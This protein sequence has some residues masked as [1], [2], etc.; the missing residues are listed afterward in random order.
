VIPTIESGD[1]A[2]SR[3]I[4]GMPINGEQA[5]ATGFGPSELFGS[6]RALAPSV[7]RELADRWAHGLVDTQATNAKRKAL[8]IACDFRTPVT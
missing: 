6:I 3:T 7:R 8:W 5:P 4:A 1:K 2:D